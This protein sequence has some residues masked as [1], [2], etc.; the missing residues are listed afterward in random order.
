MSLIAPPP[1]RG[2]SSPVST[3]CTPGWARA[4]S[5]S[6]ATIRAWARGDRA[7]AVW[8]MP[9][10]WMS[11][12]YCAAPMAF[13]AASSRGRRAPTARRS[14]VVNDSTI[15]PSRRHCDCLDDLHVT[16][17]PADIARHSHADLFH[18]GLRVLVQ[19]RRAAIASPGVQNPHWIAPD[20]TKARCTGS[21]MPSCASPS[22]VTISKPV[23]LTESDRQA[24]TA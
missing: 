23:Q 3:P 15:S 7:N 24:R 11:S 5:A 2:R 17:A 8:S 20:S 18:R 13:S 19:Q 9:G 14:P 16:G 6:T 22:T 12:R 21:R 10:S 1:S 4:A